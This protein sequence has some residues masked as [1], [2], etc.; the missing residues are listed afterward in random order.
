M[1]FTYDFFKQLNN[2]YSIPPH[3]FML[4]VLSAGPRTLLAGFP[5][6]NSNNNEFPAS[7]KLGGP[8]TGGRKNSDRQ[9]V[10]RLSRGLPATSS[11]IIR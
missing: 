5:A 11:V 7:Y 4:S 10:G 1:Y 2:T 8:H 6:K 9:K 3:N